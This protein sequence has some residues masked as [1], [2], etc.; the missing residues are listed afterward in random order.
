MVIPPMNW[1]RMVRGLMTLPA[2]K[3]PEQPRHPDLAG[4]PYAPGPRRTGLRSASPAVRPSAVPDLGTVMRDRQGQAGQHPLPV[5]KHRAGTALAVVAALLRARVA[6]PLAQRVQQAR[7][8]VNGQLVRPAST[9]NVTSA[10]TAPGTGSARGELPST[11]RPSAT[12]MRQVRPPGYPPGSA[13]NQPLPSRGRE[14]L[15]PAGVDRRRT[16]SGAWLSRAAA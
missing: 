2:A 16:G 5:Q 7:P 3:T 13:A 10:C 1:D 9:R 12:C 6:E 8:G 4:Y 11:F 15:G 14:R